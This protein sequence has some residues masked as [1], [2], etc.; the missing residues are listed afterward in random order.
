MNHAEMIQSIISKDEHKFTLF[1]LCGFRFVRHK[2]PLKIICILSKHIK[3]ESFM[4][5]RF[6]SVVVQI[7]LQI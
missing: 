2:N 6:F 1:L 5:R 3:L 7:M 4:M